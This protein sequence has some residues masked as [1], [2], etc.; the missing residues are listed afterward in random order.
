[1][2]DRLLPAGA[3]PGSAV[4]NRVHGSY[5]SAPSHYRTLPPTCGKKKDKGPVRE[6][7]GVSLL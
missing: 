4:Q 7:K 5:P 6:G 2:P 1:M 3:L